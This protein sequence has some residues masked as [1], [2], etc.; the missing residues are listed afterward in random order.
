VD[1]LRLPRVG[2]EESAHPVLAQIAAPRL[3]PAVLADRGWPLGVR[4]SSPRLQRF[5][6][7]AGLVS[8]DHRGLAL[9]SGRSALFRAVDLPRAGS[10]A[11]P[12][13]EWGL[14]PLVLRD[15]LPAHRAAFNRRRDE[16]AVA[17]AWDP[18]LAVR[19]EWGLQG[20]LA[21]RPVSVRCRCVSA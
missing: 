8:V 10:A 12:V 13:V 15:S 14:E 3:L 11:H 17:V 21:C 20:A 9:R 5:A 16:P 1:R 19:R 2:D 7:V 4:D 18:G 6:A